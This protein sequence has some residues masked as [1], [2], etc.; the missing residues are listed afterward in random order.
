MLQQKRNWRIKKNNQKQ[1]SIEVIRK[2]F[3]LTHKFLAA[4]HFLSVSLLVAIAVWSVWLISNGFERAI[5]NLIINWEVALTMT[6]GSVV[7]GGTSMG[8]GA[9]AFPVFTKVLHVPPYEAKIFSLVIQSVGMSAASLT[10]IAMKTKVEWRFIRWASLGGIPG[11]VLGSFF[12]APVLPPDSVKFFFTMMVSSFGT[13]LVLSNY[14]RRKRNLMISFWGSREQLL[15][16][17][18]GFLGGI[19]SGL[20]GT[21]MDIFC[22]SVMVLLFGLCE[23]VSTPTSVILMAINAV[24]GTI[25]HTYVIG[26][27]SEPVFSYW[28]AAVPVVVVGA[29]FGAVLS[30][31]LKR[32]TITKILIGLIIIESL[33]SFLLIPLNAPLVYFSLF[34]FA[35]FFSIYYWMYSS[36]LYVQSEY[37]QSKNY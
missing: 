30:S 36:K 19:T 22:F 11:V 3:Y 10:I 7:A 13:I 32:Q 1:N 6:F 18:V 8:G 26:D 12:L 21:G 27:F 15:S 34:V 9:V 2:W 35:L 37:F 29:P 5:S 16:I 14:S 31:L 4:R 20:V 28:L 25:L 23:K 24:V 33:S 17:V